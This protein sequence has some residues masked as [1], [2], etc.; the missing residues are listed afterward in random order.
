MVLQLLTKLQLVF[1][2]F[3]SPM[4]ENNL[5]F[6]SLYYFAEINFQVTSIYLKAV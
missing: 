3:Q 4:Q 5:I 6:I 2:L 1:F